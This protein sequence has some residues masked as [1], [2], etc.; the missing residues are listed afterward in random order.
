MTLRTIIDNGLLKNCNMVIVDDWDVCDC[1]TTTAETLNLH[2][3][4]ITKFPKD[5]EVTYD[6]VSIFMKDSTDTD[7]EL[8]FLSCST[9]DPEKYAKL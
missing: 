1:F 4:T 3:D 6:G 7:Y 2:F 8:S 5:N 9:I